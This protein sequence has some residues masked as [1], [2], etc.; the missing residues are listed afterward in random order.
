MAED[1]YDEIAQ[2]HVLPGDVML[3]IAENGDI[4]H[5]GIVVEKPDVDNLHTPKIYSKWG[6]FWEVIH[7]ANVCPYDMSRAKF[8]R[9]VK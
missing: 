9:I 3:Y 1:D 4:E 7:W 2:D 5:S 6:G 8:F